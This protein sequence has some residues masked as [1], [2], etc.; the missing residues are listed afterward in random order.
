[1]DLEEFYAADERRRHSE[2]LEFGREWRDEHGRCE[3][4]W[5]E[6]TGEVYVMRE[7]RAAL[8]VGLFGDEYTDDVPVQQ[9]AIE[10]IGVVE[11]RA[12]IQSAMHGW[13][14]AMPGENGIAWVR[15]R[16]ANAA[17]EANDPP[18]TPSDDLP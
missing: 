18:A 2:E 4:S 9:L 6:A 7:P 15:G 17:A 13:E 10:I 8:E 12:A 16:V 1:M 14:T 5:V 11:G 3:V